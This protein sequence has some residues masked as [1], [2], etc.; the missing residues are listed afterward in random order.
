VLF[1]LGEKFM[2]QPPGDMGALPSGGF[3]S[4]QTMYL[5]P[6]P[7]EEAKKLPPISISAKSTRL[8][9]LAPFDGF[10]AKNF[11]NMRV[12]VKVKGKCTTDHISAAG[13][14][15]KYKGH[16]EN[17]AENTLIGAI[18]SETNKANTAF[19]TLTNN[20]EPIPAVAKAYKANG[21]NWVVVAESN[22]GEG[23][24]REHAAMQPRYLGGRAIIAKS[25]ARIH[26]TN[27][28]K[29]G[30][31]PLTFDNPADYDAI[32]SKDVLSLKGVDTITPGTPLILHV[33][34]SAGKTTSIKLNHTM[35]K[36]QIDW[37]FAGSAMNYIKQAAKK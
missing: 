10:S 35:N 30:M 1:V 12:L 7:P 4:G 5:A 16:L 13:A 26:E 14:W 29:Q 24:A 23:S 17:I 32:S 11:E 18:N 2:L 8:Q 34:N 15:L 27:L 20:I 19:N 28:K 22:Y 33:T 25:F 31:L 3:E 6:P 9:L 21:I 36:A 37:L